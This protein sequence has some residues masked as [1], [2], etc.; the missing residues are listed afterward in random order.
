MPVEGLNA[1]EPKRPA[2]GYKSN[3]GK[4]WQPFHELRLLE[5]QHPGINFGDGD[6]DLLPL[7]AIDLDLHEERA[8]TP[9]QIIEAKLLLGRLREWFADQVC[10]IETSISG[11]GMH[12]YAALGDGWPVGR[13][14]QWALRNSGGKPIASAESFA[15][16]G[17][18]YVLVTENWQDGAAADTLPIIDFEG[19]QMA[20]LESTNEGH[21]PP[22]DAP[23]TNGWVPD[24]LTVLNP[25]CEHNEWVKV[26]MALADQADGY[27]LWD[28]WSAGGS[29][30]PGPDATARKWKSFKPHG[31][32]GLGTLWYMAKQAGWQPPRYQKSGHGGARRGA[33]RAPNEPRTAPNNE[34]RASQDAGGKSERVA[35][36]ETVERLVAGGETIYWLQDF[37]EARKGRWVRQDLAHYRRSLNHAIAR[38]Q[39]DGQGV[40]LV[41]HSTMTGYMNSLR[42]AV[43]PPCVDTALLSEEDRLGN[44]HLD[45]GALI[46]GAA[47]ENGVLDGSL[48]QQMDSR[49]FCTTSRPYPYPERDPGRPLRFDAWL[50]DRLPDPETRQAVWEL[51]GAT[52][53]QELHSLQ[54]MVALIG[55][56]RSGKGTLLRVVR[57]LMGEGAATMVFTGGPR[58]LAQSQFATGKLQHVALVQLPDMPKAPR[59]N[60]VAWDA[61]VQGL[62]ILK[63][64]TGGDPITIERKGKDLL[65]AR[66]AAGVWLDSNF[67]LDFIQGVED[68][69]AWIERLVILPV[70]QS[71]GAADQISDYEERFRPELGAIAYHAVAEYATVKE[72]GDFTRSPEMLEAQ[73]HLLNGKINGLDHFLESVK[74]SPGAW[75]SRNELKRA[76]ADMLGRSIG[77][78]DVQLIY[79]H[80]RG[81]K[82]VRNGASEGSRGFRGLALPGTAQKVQQCSSSP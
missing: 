59:R 8:D 66:V 77:A 6:A 70:E 1:P 64:L 40:A 72:R 63:S 58:R 23:D 22:P 79:R 41:G 81:L 16:G 21:S 36:R 45:T 15:T 29:D 34:V 35:V 44:F 62:G 71:I 67:D 47:F 37:Y 31:G 4:N 5:D 33:G 75:T 76:A 17:N 65:T 50:R 82:G 18:C 9:E 32:V 27:G 7:L 54:R 55:P 11:N 10:P 78:A 48:L 20:L 3:D 38:A 2:T 73:A 26:G 80:V 69:L 42:D 51:M 43:T 30:Y 68:A 28:T 52:V 49:W 74:V 53:T 19:F 57:M 60:G 39:G 12:A 13:K 14:T 46:R 25:N 24:A 56:G 61:H